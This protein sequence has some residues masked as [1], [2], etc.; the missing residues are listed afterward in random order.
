MNS[1]GWVSEQ[2][3]IEGDN[4]ANEQTAHR[5]FQTLCMC[6]VAS[7]HDHFQDVVVNTASMHM[8]RTF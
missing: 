6:N 3:S 2:T 8:E 5:A 7:S 4:C 1:Q